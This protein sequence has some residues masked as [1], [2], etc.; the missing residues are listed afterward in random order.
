MRLIWS[1]RAR[2]NLDEILDY[3]ASDNPTAA[4]KVIE[5][6]ETR[7]GLLA[8][9]PGIGRPGRVRGTRELTFAGTP[10]VVAY[11]ITREKKQNRHY[12]G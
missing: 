8:N 2:R 1:P 11:R 10:Y 6:I 12:C 7:V 9:D 4:L 5:R 3:L